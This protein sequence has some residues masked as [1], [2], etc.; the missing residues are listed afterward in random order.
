MQNLF[1]TLTGYLRKRRGFFLGLFLLGLAAVA[2]YA[3]GVELEENLNAIVPDDPRITGIS[4]AFD[5]SELSDQLVFIFRHEDSAVVEP[6]KLIHEAARLA[7][8]LEAD[9]GVASMQFRV[10]QD[11]MLGL[12]AF[13]LN[14]L[15]YFLD[16]E[17]YARL[18]QQLEP[19]A[20]EATMARNFR[21]LISPTGMATSKFV[22]QD[23]LHLGPMVL[24]KLER[25]RLDDNFITYQNC[26]FTSDL[27]HLLF[28]VD[29]VQ[30]SSN[31][32]E[33]AGLIGRIDQAI[34]ALDLPGDLR[35]DYYGG[36]AVAVANSL[37]VKKDIYLTLS[38][39]LASF[40][41]IFLVFF[42]RVQVILLMFLPVVIGAAFAMATLRWLYGE[43]S[44]IALGIGV[45]FVGI[46]IDY[47]LHLFTHMRNGED[48]KDSL[49]K[50]SLPVLM[51]AL[52]TASAF[53]CLTVI[54]SEAMNQIGLFA[55]IAV[56]VSALSVL[57]ITP[58]LVSRRTAR[59]S[60][61]ASASRT[62]FLDRLVAIPF[63]RKKGLVAAVI[64]LSVVLTFS[65]R[66]VRFNGDISTLNYQGDVL[67][68]SEALLQSIS[69]V[70]ESAVY[71]LSQGEDLNGALE[72]LEEHLELLETVRDRGLAS[73]LSTVNTFLASRREQERRI[74]RWEGF[75]EAA[76]KEDLKE[77][78][79]SAG[80]E[81]HFKA[82]AF[83]A[84]F[85]LLDQAYT[86][87]PPEAFGPLRELLLDNYISEEEGQT[88]V[89]SI[90][91]VD[92]ENKAALFRTIAPS[93]AFI[94]FDNQYFINQFFDILREDF[95]KLV[96]FSMGV[97]FL[98]LLLFFGR[99][100]IA[101]ITFIPIVISW[102]WTLG[103]MALFG[104]EINVFNIII[105]TFVFGLGIDYCI[106]LMNG[107]IARYREGQTSLDPYKLSILFSALTTV[108]AI[109]VLIFARHPALKSI[110]LVSIF[111]I[112]TVV[113]LSYTLLPLFFNF[114]VQSRGKP[115]LEPLTLFGMLATFITF[116]AFL[117]AALM[118][119]FFLPLY[120]LLPLG[121]ERKKRRI[122]WLIHRYAG[123]IVWMGFFIPKRY[124]GFERLDLEKPAVWIANHQ[125][126]LDLML[127]L[128]L[129][130]KMIV[131]VNKWVWNNFF[132][133]PLIRFADY[134]PV[135]KGLEY[136]LDKLRH[137]VDQGYSILA[138]PE[139]RR[140][141]DGKI[142]RFHQG[143]LGIADLLNLP[144]QPFL[145]HGAHDALPKT[146]HFLKAGRISVKALPP[147]RPEAVEYPEGRSYHRQARSLTAFYR[148]A[149]EALREEVADTAYY[150]RKVRSRYLYKGPVLEAYLRVKLRI[151]GH[152]EFFD[153]QIGR[154][155][156]VADLGCGYGFLAVML[157]L[158][159]P[160]RQVLGLDYD[161]QKIKVASRAAKGLNS[162][163]FEVADLAQDPL[164]EAE[165]YL[166]ND[167]LHYLPE[168]VQLDLLRRC[169]DR[170]PAGGL[171]MVRDADAA[172]QVGT[173]WTRFTEYLSTRLFAFNKTQNPLE[174]L[175]A[176]KLTE[177]AVQRGCQVESHQHERLTSNTIHL[178]RKGP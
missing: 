124:L 123:F 157:A 122:T 62:T 14:H 63:H 93:E 96:K 8:V 81:N 92:S 48:L 174:F 2:Y 135:Y 16:E 10:G 134:Y 150:A 100:E 102:T 86:P 148:E 54:R 164:P 128:S 43:A 168:A 166:L 90:L 99:L 94:I 40:L 61:N 19:G 5:R 32:R 107:I 66:K 53:L 13:V 88:T 98:I 24:E 104:I 138:F 76:G 33:N 56:L 141:P 78:I 160:K 47:S 41:L 79:R 21:T 69:S 169:L 12:Y 15:P 11:D 45:I 65:S 126:Q 175:P 121:K 51:S 18:E 38:I 171:L 125:S 55:A 111:G 103:L 58:L 178:I 159:S 77:R 127:M 35:V 173:R 115:R 113:L 131:L 75:W 7:E 71:L 139:G 95:D 101:G 140:S 52:T 108:A 130:P 146:E 27:K 64:V 149:Y 80:R 74:A 161:S 176:R 163:R 49:R 110:A 29:P 28:F 129:H 154:E 87:L 4:G 143:A 1:V 109:G 162:L 3:S 17:D 147:L 68:R 155:A 120:M 91:K 133:G 152:Y 60:T 6:E 167:V 172:Q 25:F 114:L 39:A 116:L 137:K 105:S 97:V 83:E 50:I 136:D 26:V 57:V 70:T 73:E 23:P 165:V 119:S 36:T 170:L 142:K 46:T 44:A 158:V 42:R 31:T 132:Y 145:I 72:A 30:P 85:S 82:D 177:L 118:A 117:G 9:P 84:F 20:I 144:V 151:E 34:D 59:A 106:F 89:L 112:S 37:Q 156:R 22:R 67:D 153:A